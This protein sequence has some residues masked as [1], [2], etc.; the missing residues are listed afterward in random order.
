MIKRML[1]GLAAAALSFAVLAPTTAKAADFCLQFDGEDC[2][3]SG[4]LGFFRFSGKLPKTKWKSEGLHGRSCKGVGAVQAGAAMNTVG[5][6]IKIHGTFECD[7]V[8]G[9]INAEI[10]VATGTAIGS[11][12]SG[13]GSFGDFNPGPSC[14]VT[15]VNCADELL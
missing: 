5:T 1:S 9:T 11:V 12:H 6:L 8:N 3:L 2:S 10:D 13:R 14:T 4:D 15:I 7:A